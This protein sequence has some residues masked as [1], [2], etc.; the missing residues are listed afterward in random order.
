MLECCTYVD[1]VVNGRR[2]PLLSLAFESGAG[3]CERQPSGQLSR[4]AK[5]T[6]NYVLLYT[7][8]LMPYCM[9][10]PYIAKL[11]LAHYSA[12]RLDFI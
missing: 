11:Y 12:N 8:V 2:A 7:S 9:H 3:D 6:C 4:V 1:E 5:L 10:L